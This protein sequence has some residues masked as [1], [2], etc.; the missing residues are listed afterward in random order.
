MENLQRAQQQALL[1]YVFIAGEAEEKKKKSCSTTHQTCLNLVRNA[2]NLVLGRE[3][4]QIS[5]IQTRSSLPVF[6]STEFQEQSTLEY[7]EM[8]QG[9]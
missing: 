1:S 7:V 9:D 3:L 6:I 5:Y 4:V 8:G 2:F